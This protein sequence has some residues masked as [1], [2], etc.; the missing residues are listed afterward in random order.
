MKE[1][2]R[3]V[4]NGEQSNYEI[5]DDGE[6]RNVNSHKRLK[7]KKNESGY[8][9]VNMFHN[10]KTVT[11]KVH[12]LVVEQFVPNPDNLPQ[13]NH[14]NCDKTDNRVENLE[15]TTRLDNMRHAFAN[16]CYPCGEKS[17]LSKYEKTSIEQ[18][19]ELLE[20]GNY[21]AREISE[22]SGISL[23]MV[24]AICHKKKWKHLTRGLDLGMKN[25]RNTNQC[26]HNSI[27]R[28]IIKD[29]EKSE[30]VEAIMQQGKSKEAAETLYI[31][32]KKS[33]DNGESIVQ[34]D[35]YIDEGIEIF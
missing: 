12:R 9:V 28:A 17:N 15:W 27:D 23:E 3:I 20:D 1:F 32:R 5:S 8:L 35:A 19:I 31:R 10:R 11:R 4:I 26:L 22:V 29:I 2:R 25:A 30:I 16:G 18:T 6:I 33:V 24:R 13:V 14:L 34:Y 21:T 7:P